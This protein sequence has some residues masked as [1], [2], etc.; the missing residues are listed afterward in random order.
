M[1][2]TRPTLGALINTAEAEINALIPNADARMRFSIL[3]VFARV[4]AGLTDG[5]Y[6]ALVFLSRQLFTMTATR[7]FL[8]LIAQSYGIL[9]LPSTAAQGCIL[10]QGTAGTAVLLGTLFQRG[11]G[12]RYQTTAGVILPASGYIEVGAIALVLGERGNAAAGVLLRPTSSVGGLI[13]AEVCAAAIAGGADEETDDA[14]RIRLLA[15]LRNPPGAGT[16]KDWERWTFSFSAAITRVWVVPTIYG[17]GTVG[18]VF[19]Q[20]G[21]SVIP[22]PALIAQMQTYLAQYTPAG[23]LLT[24]FAPTLKP[25]NF[26][27]HELPNADPTVRANITSELSDLLYREG[28][29]GNT[30]PLSHITEAISTAQG[31]F[32]HALTVPAAPVVMAASTPLFEIGVLGTITWA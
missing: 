23:T 22:P 5:L 28:G 9:P 25:I 27:I 3:N 21:V 6:G 26:T 8:R 16:V 10:L 20:D 11:D 7:Q 17:N 31:E 24:V 29:P 2:F 13:A 12:V 15:R 18:I 4:W 1:A 32:D 19:A 14:L 30:I